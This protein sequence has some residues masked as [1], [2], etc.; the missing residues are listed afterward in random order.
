MFTNNISEMKIWKLA[1]LEETGG[2]LEREPIGGG[3]A[4][5]TGYRP[6]AHRHTIH[7]FSFTHEKQKTST[8][9]ETLHAKVISF[10]CD[11]YDF[12][13]RF[14]TE[15]KPYLQCQGPA[16]SQTGER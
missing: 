12:T 7:H 1:Q 2:L 6:E 14:I 5:I 3:V 15:I 10:P 4:Q 8:Q 9:L 13:K 11:A 16:V